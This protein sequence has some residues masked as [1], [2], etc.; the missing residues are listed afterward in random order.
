M[1]DS[2]TELLDDIRELGKTRAELKRKI[3]NLRNT[4]LLTEEQLSTVELSLQ[5]SAAKLSRSMDVKVQL[6]LD[7]SK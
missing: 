1:P 3:T 4:L 5:D 7:E 6:V 2:D